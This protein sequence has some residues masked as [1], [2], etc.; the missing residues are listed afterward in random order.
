M[1]MEQDKITVNT[2]LSAEL[3]EVPQEQFYDEPAKPSADSK[4]PAIS[5]VVPIYNV[6]DYLRR[7][8]DSLVNQTFLDIEI[9]CV[10]DCSPDPR[11]AEIM[12]E[13]QQRYPNLI[14]CLWHKENLKHGGA[15]RTGMKAARG[16]YLMALDPDD[17]YDEKMCEEMYTLAKKDDADYVTCDVNRCNTKN[18]IIQYCYYSMPDFDNGILDN[19]IFSLTATVFWRVCIKRQLVIENNLYPT[20]KTIAGDGEIGI[21]FYLCSKKRSYV[22]KPLYYYFSSRE[23]SVTT[24]NNAV[25]KASRLFSYLRSAKIN[26]LWYTNWSGYVGNNK[27]LIDAYFLKTFYRWT[28][29]ISWVEILM[30]TDG[31]EEYMQIVKETLEILDIDFYSE[32]QNKIFE[33][34]DIDDLKIRFFHLLSKSTD[35]SSL[36]S[37]FLSIVVF[38]HYFDFVALEKTIKSQYPNGAN[39]TIWGSGVLGRKLMLCFKYSGFEEIGFTINITDKNP[40]TCRKVLENIPKCSVE[41]DNKIEPFSELVD[42]TDLLIIADPNRYDG[43]KHEA[44]SFGG[45]FTVMEK[46]SFK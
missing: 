27:R 44:K 46:L 6:A 20:N 17:Y 25:Y 7:S 10:N 5:I 21:R 38:G 8:L 41:F 37:L 43:I 22:H 19:G 28:F 29:D 3:D 36:K 2:Q 4:P 24:E 32:I 11:D 26:A 35:V 16:E 45:S 13:Y 23:G 14:R 31:Y 1:N 40:G 42:K 18:N 39:I 34:N 30:T 33:Q 9:I 15:S 12:R